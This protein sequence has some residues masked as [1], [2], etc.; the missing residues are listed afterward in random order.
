M[1]SPL[2]MKRYYEQI[3]EGIDIIVSHQPPYMHG[4]WTYYGNK[5]DGSREL[6][7]TIMRV[8]PQ[9]VICGHF[10]GS[11]GHHPYVHKDRAVTDVYNVSLVNE[12]YDP[13]N[14]PMA[15]EV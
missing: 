11:Y 14:A 5:N 9:A 12:K 3:P 4:D 15:I 2:E 8:R 6:L 10:H 1:R 7:S 13:V